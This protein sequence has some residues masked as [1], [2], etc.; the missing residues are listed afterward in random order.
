MNSILEERQKDWGNPV[1]TH[2]RIA[3]V[4]SGILNYHIT[5]HQVALMMAGLKL[6]RADLNPGD[7]DSYVDARAYVRIAADF[8]GVGSQL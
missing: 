4:W 3:R 2:R 7:A 6:V 8:R 5:A 1:D